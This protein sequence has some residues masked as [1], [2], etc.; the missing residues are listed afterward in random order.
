MSVEHR[1]F[2]AKP[3]KTTPKQQQAYNHEKADWMRKNRNG[4]SD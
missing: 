4:N 1:Q 3:A 2:H